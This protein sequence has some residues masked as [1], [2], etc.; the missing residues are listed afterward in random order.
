MKCKSVLHVVLPSICSLIASLPVYSSPVQFETNFYEFI[1]AEGISWQD[2]NVAATNSTFGNINGYLTTIT[3][4]AESNFLMGQFATFSGFAGAW[5]GGEVNTSGAGIWTTGS[6]IGQIFSQ[7]GSAVSGVY[8]NWGGVEPNGSYPSFAY[9]NI[10]TPING[11]ITGQWADATNGVASSDDLI[12]GYFVEY[13]SPVPLPP[14]LLL[15]ITGVG[16]LAG[17]RLGKKTRLSTK[18]L[19]N[20]HSV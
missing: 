15:Y 8:A 6:E 17:F 20:T 1:A 16:G 19:S 3:K 11:V 7:G 4:E 18:A 12:K 2:A 10:G 9:M 14:A 13:A 5:L